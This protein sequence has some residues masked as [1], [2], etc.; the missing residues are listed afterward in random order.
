MKKNRLYLHGLDSVENDKRRNA[1]PPFSGLDG[2]SRVFFDRLLSVKKI[3]EFVF[4]TKA[5]ARTR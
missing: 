3:R 5:K 2:D 1:L 4:I